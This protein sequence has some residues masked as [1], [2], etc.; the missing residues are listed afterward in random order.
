MKRLLLV[1]AGMLV[2]TIYAIVCW[3]AAGWIV[4]PPRKPLLAIH[5]EQ[6]AHMTAHGIRIERR[7]TAQGTPYLACTP[8]AG[9]EPGE[10][11]RILRSQL[12]SRHV[13]PPPYGQTRA[14]LVLLHGW[15][16]RKEDLLVTAER[17]CAVGFRCLIPDLPGHGENPRSVTNFGGTPRERKLPD[18]IWTDAQSAAPVRTPR[19]LWGI[20]MGGA[21]A[22]AAAAESPANWDGV[23]AVSAFD[24]LEPVIAA[25]AELET[26]SWIQIFEPGLIV[27]ARIRSEIWL[28]AANPIDRAR[29]LRIP[30]F[31]VHGTEDD[32]I[33]ISAG[34][35]LFASIATPRKRWLE[36]T[37]ARHGNVLATPQ[38][39]FA[40]MAGWLLSNAGSPR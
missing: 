23:I 9:H 36:V 8:F 38:P 6:L 29:R 12:L 37:A 32:L 30:A 27:A 25:R 17:F 20:S 39:V 11:G 16:M 28:P 34:R 21:W 24:A 18:E 26:G 2:P 15:R 13:T 7:R 10:R 35:R 4:Q 14:T 31:L 40:E 3:Q 33:P 5:R 22:L 1:A 19:Y